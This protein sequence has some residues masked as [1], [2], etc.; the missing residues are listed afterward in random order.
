M[1]LK[2][3]LVSV[4]IICVP[5]L[6]AGHSAAGVDKQTCLVFERELDSLV[7]Q[8]QKFNVKDLE[9]CL[10]NNKITGS[11]PSQLANYINLQTLS[12]GN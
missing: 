10:G 1:N 3:M 6:Y 9:E 2:R 4:L 11:L 5:T 8:R 12:L 7:K